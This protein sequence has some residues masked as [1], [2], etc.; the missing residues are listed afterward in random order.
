MLAL[1]GPQPGHRGAGPGKCWCSVF[2]PRLQA[3]L[4]GILDLLESLR[5]PRCLPGV[6]AMPA[7]RP[8]LPHHSCVIFLPEASIRTNVSAFVTD[9][10][11]QQWTGILNLSQRLWAMRGT[12]LKG[13]LAAPRNTG[14]TKATA[15][16]EAMGQ[17]QVMTM[18]PPAPP[19]F[20]SW[21]G[22]RKWRCVC[23]QNLLHIR[24][25]VKCQTNCRNKSHS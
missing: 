15:T 8:P 4:V 22:P 14:R 16:H 1:D 9:G 25:W 13:R 3:T 18:R 17:R 7:S 5:C 11:F 24:A 23:T 2:Q 20:I 19:C 21:V 10:C 12:H 6:P